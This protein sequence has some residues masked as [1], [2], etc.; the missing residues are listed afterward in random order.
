MQRVS[1]LGRKKQAPEVSERIP[2]SNTPMK[3]SNDFIFLLASYERRI[4]SIHNIISNRPP[5][6]MVTT[7]NNVFTEPNLFYE[8]AAIFDYDLRFYRKLK[9]LEIKMSK[10]VYLRSFCGMRLTA[11]LLD[12][13]GSVSTGNVDGFKVYTLKLKNIRLKFDDYLAMIE[14]SRPSWLSMENIELLNETESSFMRLCMTLSKLKIQRIDIHKCLLSTDMFILLIERTKISDF[15]YNDKLGNSIIYRTRTPFVKFCCVQEN[16]VTPK[17]FHLKEIEYLY[18]RGNYVLLDYIKLARDLKYLK[19]EAATLNGS[20]VKLLGS[21]RAVYLIGCAFKKIAFYEFVGVLAPTLRYICLKNTEI[22]LDGL[23]H[24]RAIL[25]NC[26][27]VISENTQ[28]FI[29]RKAS[30]CNH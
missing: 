28:F 8:S 3:L 10:K 1:S 4:Y 9:N 2:L 5:C 14:V 16:P 19:L 12:S 18:I 7:S 23:S 25:S 20:L 11:L 13:V 6:C 22:P 30:F 29:P 15:F 24:M 26:Q 27:V 17:H 21:L